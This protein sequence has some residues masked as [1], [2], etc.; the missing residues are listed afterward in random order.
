MYGEE[1]NW[2]FNINIFKLLGSQLIS[3]KFTAIIELV[4]NSYDANATE[5]KIDF[6]SN[7]ITLSDNGIGMGLDDIKNKWMTIGTNNKRISSLSPPPF[8]RVMLGEKGVGRFAIEKIANLITI[9]TKQE[10]SK[11]IHKLIIDWSN[12][13]KLSDI[14]SQELF[15]SIGNSYSVDDAHNFLLPSGLSITFENLKESWSDT[16]IKR[17]KIELAKLVSPTQIALRDNFKIFVKDHRKK[18]LF[19][20]A[21]YEEIVNNSLDYASKGYRIT[22]G[23]DFQEILRFDPE[24]KEMKVERESIKSFGPVDIFIYYFDKDSKAKFRKTYEK[25]DLK[26]DG[27]KV[28][29][30]GIL[31]TPFVE[32]AN[33]DAGVDKYRDILGIDKRRWSNFFGKIS[34]HDFIGI[35]EITK[36]K[37]PNIKDLT[38]RQ[39]F[40][41]TKEYEEFKKFIIAQLIAIENE[42]EYIKTQEKQIQ[43]ERE[44]DIKEKIKSIIET[45]KSIAKDAPSQV[46]QELLSNLKNIDNFIK[47]SNNTIKELEQKNQLQEQ[48]YQ[49][50]MSLQEYAAEL[51]HMVR[52]SLVYIISTLNF[53]LKHLQ[54]NP[55]Y[56]KIVSIKRD[57]KNLQ[58]DI[59]Y[60]LD[61]ANKAK[62][63]ER[64]NVTS[65]LLDAFEKHNTV[66]EKE[67]IK[68]EIPRPEDFFITHIPTFVR[69]VFNNLISNSIKALKDC[70]DKKIKCSAFL[71]SDKFIII[72]SD[73][74]CGIKEEN[75]HKIY[76]RYFSTYENGS[77]IGLYM[78]KNNLKA[79]GATIDLIQPEFEQGCSFE[80]KIPLERK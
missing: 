11:T 76:D 43:K 14:N 64:F 53:L 48:T 78:V 7:K 35:I 21:E 39:D 33:P 57:I 47:C 41:N 12:Y 80:I 29:R 28:Y 77:G 34:S 44:V 52:N 26:I 22:S 25:K 67:E 58:L 71:E 56:D 46:K 61:Y 42:L 19:S 68:I 51:A 36:N 54:D 20:V 27:F 38:N 40:E 8:N 45:T 69:D 75:K 60:M 32:I 5:I 62:K 13:E 73:N 24:C 3:D 2:K 70:S 65:V 10:H 6:Y 59:E 31:T 74:G 50:L 79:I 55:Y 30:D 72:F 37:N 16:D 66:F 49:S 4:K 18:D 17:L 15:T 1:L 63:T 9:R 23:D